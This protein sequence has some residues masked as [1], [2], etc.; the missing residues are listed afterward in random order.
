[1]RVTHAISIIYKLISFFELISSS[2]NVVQ[3]GCNELRCTQPTAN[4]GNPVLDF[5]EEGTPNKKTPN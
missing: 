1:M 2:L 4:E 5:P 3:V